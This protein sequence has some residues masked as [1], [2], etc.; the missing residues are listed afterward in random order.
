M[1][2]LH[3][4]RRRCAAAFEKGSGAVREHRLWSRH[5]RE[6]FNGHPGSSLPT[7]EVPVPTSG[8]RSGVHPKT[9]L[10]TTTRRRRALELILA[11]MAVPALV[12]L[13]TG[14]STAW[15][16]FI[17]M[18]PIFCIYLAVVLYA[19]RLRAVEEMNVAFF[20]NAKVAPPAWED[21]FAVGDSALEEISA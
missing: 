19:R 1:G 21:I 20:G 4:H 6:R 2:L 8:R 10:D 9:H 18:L 5:A 17:G 13:A 12:A 15:W 7:K 14:S 3:R 11:V 16:V